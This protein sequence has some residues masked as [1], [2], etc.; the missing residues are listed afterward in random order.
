[1]RVHLNAPTLQ[2]E[3]ED[4]GVCGAVERDNLGLQGLRDRV[5]AVGGRFSVDSMRGVGTLVAAR[6]PA[7]IVDSGR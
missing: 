1:M 7:T 3:I 4:D 6:F 5:E 2:L